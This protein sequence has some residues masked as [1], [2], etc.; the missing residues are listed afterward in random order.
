MDVF[1]YY[2][3]NQ[4]EGFA[5]IKKS[6]SRKFNFKMK[7]IALLFL[8]VITLSSCSPEEDEAQFY[9]EVLPVE[10]F[11]VP[12]SVGIGQTYEVE[13]TYKRPSDCHFYD[14]CYYKT[15]SSSTIVG[16]QTYVLDLN[17]CTTLE[18]EAPIEVSFTFKVDGAQN[19][20]QPY[21]FKFYKGKD[22]NGNDIFEEVQIPITY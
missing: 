16:I 20:A 18:D 8:A 1:F 10:S 5:S 17:N 22:T 21:T 9:Y 15:E 19:L 14:G 13:M 3:R 7:K 12:Q 2:K 4:T 11:K 6:K